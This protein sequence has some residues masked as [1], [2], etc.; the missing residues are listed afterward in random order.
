MPIFPKCSVLERIS[1]PTLPSSAPV[2]RSACQLLS[3]IASRTWPLV[4]FLVFRPPT[5]WIVLDVTR[6]LR[7]RWL[8]DGGAKAVRGRSVGHS[9]SSAGSLPYVALSRLDRLPKLQ[10]FLLPI[11]L[12]NKT[13]TKNKKKKK[14]KQSFSAL[15]S[16]SSQ[17]PVHLRVSLLH[18]SLSS[19]KH[20][21]Y[22]HVFHDHKDSLIAIPPLASLFVAFLAPFPKTSLIHSAFR[23]LSSQSGCVLPR[24][25]HL[26]PPLS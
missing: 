5:G 9:V 4:I 12:I 16:A 6:H 23:L 3:A 8:V 22:S 17:K 11:N 2:L 10:K 24:H 1:T 25:I 19:S 15:S 14:K 13:K 20:F 26:L 7:D 18:H 21:C